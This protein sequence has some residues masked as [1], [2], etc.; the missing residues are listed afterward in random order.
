MKDS[1]R[2]ATEKVTSAAANPD[3]DKAASLQPPKPAERRRAERRSDGKRHYSHS[4]GAYKTE[5]RNLL[6]RRVCDKGMGGKK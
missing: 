2:L 1:N 6:E 5:R 4:A 3:D